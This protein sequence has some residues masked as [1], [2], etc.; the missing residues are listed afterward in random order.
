MWQVCCFA[1]ETNTLQHFLIASLYNFWFYSMLQDLCNTSS[2]IFNK[3]ET[4]MTVMSKSIFGQ[5]KVVKVMFL[6]RK[7][8]SIVPVTFFTFLSDGEFAFT[9][10]QTQPSP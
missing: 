2:H 4:A 8:I 9:E 3:F 1:C 7:V 5:P 10:R 6:C